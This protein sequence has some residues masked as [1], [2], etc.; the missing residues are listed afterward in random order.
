MQGK[1]RKTH[2]RL[3]K[4]LEFDGLFVWHLFWSAELVE[5]LFVSKHVS[6]CRSTLSQALLTLLLL[7]QWVVVGG[8]LKE[9]HFLRVMLRLKQRLLQM[10]HGLWRRSQPIARRLLLPK[11]LVSSTVLM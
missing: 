6:G 9:G 5:V 4:I 2:L 1:P 3:V 11:R 8:L 7:P 10:I